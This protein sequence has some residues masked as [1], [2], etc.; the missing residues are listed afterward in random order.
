MELASEDIIILTEADYSFLSRDVDKLL[1]YIPE[2]DMVI[3]TRT[4]RQLIKQGSTM[5]GLVRFANAFLGR[6]V[7]ILWWNRRS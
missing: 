5:R 7:E 2:S 3:G 4:T 1:T 6:V